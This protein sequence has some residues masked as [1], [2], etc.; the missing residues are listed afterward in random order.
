MFSSILKAG[1]G[2]RSKGLL[3][4]GPYNL[5]KLGRLPFCPFLS[6]FRLTGELNRRAV[7]LF[8]CGFPRPFFVNIRLNVDWKAW[9][10]FSKQIVE[11]LL[12]ARKR[13]RANGGEGRGGENTKM[14][15]MCGPFFL[16]TQSLLWPAKQLFSITYKGTYG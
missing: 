14:N 2:K 16:G 10:Q 13:N 1:L 8:W 12:C 5:A 15:K 9:I 4:L 6:N 11:H 7:I 3:F